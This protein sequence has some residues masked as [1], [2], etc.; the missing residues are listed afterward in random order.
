VSNTDSF[1]DEVTEEVRRDR[2]YGLMRRYGWIGILLVVLIVGGT[3]WREYSR[4]QAESRAQAF[5]DSIMTALDEAEPQARIAAL[6]AVAAPGP[7]GQ[8]ILDLLIASEQGSAGEGAAA[9]ERLGAV[10]GNTEVPAI[11]RQIAQFKALA[12]SDSGMDAAARRAG[13]EALAVPG[14]PLNLLAQEQ[15]ALL[16]IEAGDTAAATERLRAIVADSAA[17]T[18]LRRRAQQLIVALGGTLD[19]G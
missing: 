9:A 5:G 11:Y 1:I 15:L 12:R 3:A 4:A 19:E 16:E 17:T 2:L 10:S 18:G 7:E 14:E 8:A 13:F 6:G